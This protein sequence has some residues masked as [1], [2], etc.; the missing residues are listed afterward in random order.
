[1]KQIPFVLIFVLYIA[2]LFAE[3]LQSVEKKVY[4][5]VR[6]NPHPP[7]ID[8][9][10]DDPI[11]QQAPVGNKFVQYEPKQNEM[12]SEE[13]L[14]QIAYDENYLYVAFRALDSQPDRIVRRMTRRDQFSE[15]N[16]DDIGSFD[17]VGI[18]LDSYFDHL[19][20]FEFSVTPAG[21]RGDVAWSENGARK[22]DSW[23]P[24]WY[25]KTNVDNQGWTAEMKIPLSQ[26]RFGKKE[27]HVWGLEVFRYLHRKQ[28]T[29]LWQF[30]PRDAPGAVHM[31]GELRGISGIAPLRHIELMP[32]SVSSAQRFKRETGNPF[33]TG[34]DSQLSGGLDGK[35]GLSS[36]MTMDFTINPDFGQVEADP[37]EVNLTA[38]ETFF[39]EK[40]PF[41]VEGK[42]IF[43][44]PLM[45]G[46]G[47]LANN[48]LFYSR[49]IGRAPHREPDLADEEHMSLPQ[50]T[51]ILGALKV[52]GK[53]SNGLSIGLLDA[54]TDKE[55]AEIESSGS[56]RNE[57]VEPKTNYFVGRLQ[58]S[59]RGGSSTLGGMFTATH[60]DINAPYLNSLTHSAYTGG[61]DLYHQWHNRTY[62]LDIRTAFSHLRGHRDAILELQTASARYFQRPDAPHVSVDSSR[63]SLSGHGGFAGIG[64]GGNGHW[65]W[66]LGCFWYSP[67]LELNDIGFLGRA[68][69]I[70][71]FS[72]A[73][74]RVYKPV[75]IFRR[76][77]LNFNQWAGW[78]FGKENLYEGMNVNGNTQFN[79]YWWLSLGIGREGH[80]LSV[81]ELRGGPAILSPD[82]LN[83]WWQI[84]SDT[85]KLLQFSLR[86]F[87]AAASNGIT[88]YDNL[89]S[90]FSLRPSNALM[91][92][93]EPFF[94]YT[95][96]NLQYIDTI[97]IH[98]GPRYIFGRIDQK[99]VG[100]VLRLNYSLTPNLSLQYYGQ[101]FVSAGKYTQLKKITQPRARRYQDRYHVFTSQEITYDA[102]SET[103]LIDENQDNSPDYSFD[104]PD[105]NFRQFR[106][107]LVLRWEYHPGSTLFVVWSQGRTGDTSSGR[108]SFRNDMSELFQVYPE[109]IFL[110]KLNH[111]FSL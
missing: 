97:E 22:D 48:M 35:I 49:R 109:N 72:W 38:F 52:S 20:A 59:Y 104:K 66:V 95:K 100:A 106:S 68:D 80:I 57:V 110:I 82:F 61:I 46:D 26:L 86:G 69:Q 74:Y 42:G 70:S 30:I 44:F 81:S 111:W 91:I 107:N 83:T 43:S 34:K 94:R 102:G 92:S 23:D 53:T 12:P 77:N 9:R 37:S 76:I 10:L 71:Q 99:T 13:T 15:S 63:T 33:A 60:R 103:Y 27:E 14:F 89:R 87:R 24:V 101:P 8:G 7:A 93:C 19:S 79:N 78:S 31:F 5:A 108:F 85:R 62:F 96:D 88:H 51:S 39:Q 16:M 25:V 84:E 50:R 98:D 73:G 21:V 6:N 41:F 105:F 1:M 29:S 75:W 18:I 32:Y 17:R 11:W 47:D 2:N 65:Q 64:K 28:E 40:R 56:R 58:K 36:N 3:Q 90:G 4:K 55:N 54:V 45:I 67:G